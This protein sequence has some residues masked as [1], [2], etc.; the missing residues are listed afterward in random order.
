M[1]GEE[2][3]VVLSIHLSHYNAKPSPSSNDIFGV[4]KFFLFF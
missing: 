4:L 2:F 3:S 1:L